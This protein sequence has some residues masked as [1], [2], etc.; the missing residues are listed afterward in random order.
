MGTKLNQDLHTQIDNVRQKNARKILITGGAGYI[1]SH[2]SWQ[3]VENGFQPIILDNFSTGDLRNCPDD[4]PVIKGDAS[5]VEL[6]KNVLRKHDVSAVIH[7]AGAIQVEESVR[8]PLKYYKQN[9]MTTGSAL[10]ACR[11]MGVSQF[12]FSSTAAVYGSAKEAAAGRVDEVV[13]LNPANPYGHSKRMA[14]QMIRDCGKAFGIR[15]VCLRYFNVAGVHPRMRSGPRGAGATHLIKRACEVATGKRRYLEVYGS[16]YPTPDGTGVRD[17]IHVA[18]LSACH[19]SALQY[20]QR[21]GESTVLNCGYGRGFS[22]LDIVSAFED[23]LDR[24]LPVRIADR[25]AGDVASL[26]A[27][28][29]RLCQAFPDWKESYSDIHAIVTSALEWETSQ[30]ECNEDKNQVV[31]HQSRQKPDDVSTRRMRFS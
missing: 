20:L 24:P 3:L 15:S 25:R 1:G 21:G 9:L 17:Y 13:P 23:I 22:V 7:F 27:E 31:F 28:N 10:S 4:V 30:E 29:K 19:L 6:F 2:V 8:D 12:I 5:N 16:D 14:E 11:D 18:D 26:V